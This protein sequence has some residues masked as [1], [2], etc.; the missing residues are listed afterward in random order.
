MLYPPV[1]KMWGDSSTAIVDVDTD[2]RHWEYG[3][4]VDG[5]SVLIPNF[6]GIKEDYADYFDEDIL[7]YGFCVGEI[8]EL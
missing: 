2:Y 1:I 3:D 7:G 4:H 8:Y 5:A 6:K